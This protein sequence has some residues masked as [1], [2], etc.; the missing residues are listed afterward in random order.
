MS[1]V[2]VS[3]GSARNPSHVHATGSAPPSIVSF[4]SSSAVCG[5]GPAERTGKSS[6]TYCPGGKR[7]LSSPRPR[8]RKPRETM[9]MRP[10][11]HA[12]TRAKGWGQTHGS[13]PGSS[14][15]AASFHKSRSVRQREA[16]LTWRRTHAAR[17]REACS[18]GTE[19]SSRQPRKERGGS[20]RTRY[21]REAAYL[22]GPARQA[23]GAT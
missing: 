14:T 4:H 10:V 9:P 21:L 11:C 17:T 5:V 3:D 20:A 13:D 15:R 12:Q 23:G 19:G 18:R 2:R 8:P 7:P 22:L 1:F 16:R 6:V